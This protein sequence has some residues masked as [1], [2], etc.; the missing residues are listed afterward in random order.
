[1]TSAYPQ[2]EGSVPLSLIE[3]D[4]SYSGPDHI[5]IKELLISINIR[6]NDIN[7]YVTA[8]SH[9]S[10][11]KQQSYERFEFLGDSVLSTAISQYLVTRYPTSDEGFL[12]R[13]RSKLVRGSTQCEI[14]RTLG[15]YKVVVLSDEAERAGKRNDDSVLEDVFEA[16]VGALFIDKGFNAASAWIK[17]V[18]ETNVD[19]SGVVQLEVTDKER[20]QR[21]AATKNDEL[22]FDTT[23]VANGRFKVIVRKTVYSSDS[24]FIIG[25]GEGDSK[26]IASDAACKRALN[27][28]SRAHEA[29]GGK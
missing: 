8:F 1:M 4:T 5:G 27:H 28:Y 13:M 15:L 10:T 20:L 16:L 24:G 22:S 2:E 26:K 19:F 23:K 11:G 3:S 29:K 9:R 12:T 25:V 7:L 6:P 14:A 18:Y 17:T 21:I